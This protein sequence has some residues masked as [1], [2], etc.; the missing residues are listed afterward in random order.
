MKKIFII[1]LFLFTLKNV[2]A[3]KITLNGYIKEMEGIYIFD[4]PIQTPSDEIDI[5]SY[6]LLH[7]RLNF[8]FYPTSNLIIALE[9]RNRLFSGKI[10]EQIPNYAKQ[11]ASD[12][13]L[14]D[15]S[16]NLAEGDKYFV[17]TTIDRFYFDY[18]INDWQIRAGRQRI[19]WGINLVWNPNDI[20]NAF[21]YI[22]F[23]YEERPGSDA[24]LMT[25][26]PTMSSSVDFAFKAADSINNKAFAAK[27]RFNKFNY[28]FQLLAGNAGYDYVLG[29]GWSGNI[30]NF[31]FRGEASYFKPIKKYKDQSDEGVSASISIDYSFPN[32]LYIHTSF[33]YNGFGTTEKGQSFSLI[34]P[35]IQLSAK[36]LSIGKYELF[37]QVSYPIGTLI[38]ISGAAMLNP[39]DLS[40]F[41]EPSVAF[42]LQD[43]LE[44][45]VNS[46][47]MMGDKNTEY[48]AMGNLY[49]LFARL[50]WSF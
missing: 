38:N 16:W 40:M 44:F 28:D 37:G 49:A 23:D 20:F 24:I 6:N 43:N 14:V 30:W 41:V 27:Y 50:R 8:K 21:S 25:W 34:D 13:G 33:L 47:I 31:G 42:S 10:L 5:M 35:S 48:A 9:L 3:Q 36:K 12:N 39:I 26:Y 4:N 32:S 2:T 19:N 17:N 11:I 18:T 46:Q 15:L 29:G 22:D 7:N 45:Y 1:V